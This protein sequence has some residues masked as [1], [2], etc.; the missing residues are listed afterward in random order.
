MGHLYDYGRLFKRRED[1]A[2][3]ALGAVARLSYL[4]APLALVFL[5]ERSGGQGPELA[6]AFSIGAAVGY[7]LSSALSVRY[8][9][10]RVL[11]LT[12]C[13]AAILGYFV[14]VP[15]EWRILCALGCGFVYPP[16]G[17]I[18]RSRWS[19]VLTSDTERHLA[20]AFEA[21]LTEVLTIA[22]PIVVGLLVAV[23][24]PAYAWRSFIAGGLLSTIGACVYLG[25][26]RSADGAAAICGRGSRALW[27]R[28]VVSL[29]GTV[30]LGAA[31]IAVAQVSVAAQ[32][33]EQ[34]RSSWVAVLL[35]FLGVSSAV[36]GVWYGL[37]RQTASPHIVYSGALAL[38][39][40]GLALTICV[41]VNLEPFWAL[42]L[43]ACAGLPIAVTAIEEFALLESAVPPIGLPP[44]VG[45]LLSANS[46]GA[47]LG[48]ST[49][50]VIRD[51][52]FGGAAS[53][54][55]ALAFMATGA[56]LGAMT[57]RESSERSADSTQ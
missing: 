40:V 45:L 13:G 6:A 29:L 9:A 23:L 39:G 34:G 20:R 2:V 52:Q 30:V 17:P 56:L 55:A 19:K 48:A 11:L 25:R 26:Q 12:V 28:R 51:M 15:S 50:G 14:S 4:A 49:V 31:G 27:G 8:G 44:A 38:S 16:V 1:V 46:A 57:F 53:S 37:R 36:G 43:A 18:L 7:P 54:G 3:T 21:T 5:G 24:S 35:S 22:G 42:P 32:L 10:V 33:I 41:A 47:A